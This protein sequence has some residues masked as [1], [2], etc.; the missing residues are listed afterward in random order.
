VHALH[1]G[2]T[3]MP[4]SRYLDGPLPRKAADARPDLTGFVR[5]PEQVERLS[6]ADFFTLFAELLIKNPPHA[7]DAPMMAEPRKIGIVPGKFDPSPLGAGGLKAMEDG[8]A[9]VKARLNSLDGHN[10]KAGPTGWTG[11][12][13]FVGRYG[14]NYEIRAAV[15]RTGLGANPP[16]DATYLHSHQDDA[17]QPLNG[18][19]AYRIHFAKNE[20]PPVKTFWSLTVYDEQGYFT[21]KAIAN[22][23]LHSQ[24]L[25]RQF[26]KAVTQL[27]DLQ[28]TRRAEQRQNMETVLDLMEICESKGETYRPTDDG[29]VFSPAALRLRKLQRQVEKPHKSAAAELRQ[30]AVTG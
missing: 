22:L 15:A 14:T 25:A 11:G 10:G 3:L 17:G 23:S 4:L 7:G 24:R 2:Y 9:A 8:A 26:E 16:E 21:A 18:S 29:F 19:R 30:R 13:K 12:S 6:A 1:D 27:R 28:K 5:P 20:I